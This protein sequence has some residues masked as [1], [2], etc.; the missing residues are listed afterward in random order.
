LGV[1]FTFLPTTPNEN[2]WERVEAEL[3]KFKSEFDN[4]KYVIVVDY[5]KPIFRKRLWVLNLKTKDIALNTHISH[6]WNSGFFKA[7]KFS[8]VIGSNISSK[9]TFKTLNSYESNYGSGDYKIGMKI[10]GLEIGKND[11]SL[12][13]AIVFH[14]SWGFWS[15]GCF[16]SLPWINKEIIDLTKGGTIL[17][18]N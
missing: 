8:N 12:K 18:V 6:A 7:E 3:T 13:R 14:S 5:S 17:I 9:G 1:G 11:N 4:P 15:S 10:K 2:V 16:M